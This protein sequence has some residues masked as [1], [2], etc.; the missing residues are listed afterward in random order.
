MVCQLQQYI[1]LIPLGTL[2]LDVPNGHMCN[3]YVFLTEV[4]IPNETMYVFLMN[5]INQLNYRLSYRSLRSEAHSNY[6]F[7]V[8]FFSG[9]P[10]RSKGTN[11]VKQ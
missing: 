6:L 11:V 7:E 8:S 5:L 4:C 2:L 3:G 10:L 9:E 1:C